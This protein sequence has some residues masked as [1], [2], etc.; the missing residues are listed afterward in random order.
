MN[1]SAMGLVRRK[2]TQKKS[3]KRSAGYLGGGGSS[4]YAQKAARRN[5]ITGGL[6]FPIHQGR[7]QA[8]RDGGKR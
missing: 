3:E 7:V 8:Q 2:A 4:K 6:P 5:R 1:K